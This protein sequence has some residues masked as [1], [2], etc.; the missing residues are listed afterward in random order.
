MQS[1]KRH[2]PVTQAVTEMCPQ[3]ES[4]LEAEMSAHLTM[5]DAPRLRLA[6]AVGGALLKSG[7]GHPTLGGYPRTIIFPPSLE[8]DIIFPL[9]T[10]SVSLSF[11]RGAYGSYQARDRIRATAV[12][13]VNPFDLLHRAGDRTHTTKKMMPDP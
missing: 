10:D 6:P 8:G 11:L 2:P 7:Q 5:A 3:G 1:T 12:A 13:T 9:G 4:E